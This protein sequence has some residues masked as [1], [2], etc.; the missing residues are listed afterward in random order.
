MTLPSSDS[1]SRSVT[2]I[3]PD[4]PNDDPENLIFDGNSV[5]ED[6]APGAIIGQISAFDPDGDP[7]TYSVDD[8]RFS[9]DT[10]NRLVVAAGAIFDAAAEP[11]INLVISATDNIS[12]PVTLPTVL[13]VTPEASLLVNLVDTATDVTLLEVVPGATYQFTQAQLDAMGLY[14]EIPSGHPLDGQVQSV[15]LSL[16]GN[17]MRTEIATPYALFGDSSGNF[18]PGSIS[19]G[20]HSLT[21]ELYSAKSAQGTL[22]DTQV[23]SFVLTAR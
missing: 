11:Q 18:F 7:I 17:V 19:A 5:Y 16:D 4:P 23:V 10:Q 12:N 1:T 3:A 13:T 22:L 15:V 14:T 20:A 8:A 6:S 21:I 9:V 2:V